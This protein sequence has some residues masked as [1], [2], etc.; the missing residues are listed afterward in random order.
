MVVKYITIPLLEGNRAVRLQRR[1]HRST[2]NLFRLGYT[3]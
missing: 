1:G 2:S 3:W